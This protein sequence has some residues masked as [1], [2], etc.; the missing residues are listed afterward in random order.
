MARSSSMRALPVAVGAYHVALGGFC[1][2]LFSPDPVCTFRDE[3]V[4]L[5]TVVKVHD[6]R[7]VL[8]PTVC[9][10]FILQAI[11]KLPHVLKA[12]LKVLL[13]KV[14]SALGIAGLVVLYTLFTMPQKPDFPVL[15]L[16]GVELV[17]VKELLAFWTPLSFLGHTLHVTENYYTFK[18]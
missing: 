16:G 7:R 9:A 8:D 10:S 13:S 11:S 17:S 12:L 1:K 6:I 14:W 3:E 15:E 4:F 2:E 5:P 18:R